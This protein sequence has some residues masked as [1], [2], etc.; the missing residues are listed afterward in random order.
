MARIVT[1]VGARPQLVKAAVV[2]IALR[3][4]AGIEEILVHTGQHYDDAMSAV[5]FRELG[6]PDPSYNLG[7]GSGPHGRQTGSMLSALEEVLEKEKP[8]AVMVYG[9]TNSTLAGALAAAKLSLRVIHVEAGLRS[10]NRQM[11]EEIN[12]V[13][14]DH[15][16][17]LLFAPTLTARENLLHEGLGTRRIELPGDVMYDA[18]LTFS[19]RMPEARTAPLL[20]EAAPYVLATVHR[21]ENTDHATRLKAILSALCDVSRRLP[22]IL[23]LHPRTRAVIGATFDDDLARFPNLILCP[24]VGYLEMLQLERN[25]SLVVT[26]SGGV[27]KEAFFFRV[28]C[29]TVREETEWVE[30]VESGW[31]RLAPPHDIDTIL[32]AISAALDAPQGRADDAVEGLFGG[33][34]AGSRIARFI[35]EFVG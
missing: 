34:L 11:P 28:P 6:I 27:Q 12:R 15:L 2:S 35:R 1:V 29:V 23:P 8:D 18:T 13:T 14:T 25:A 21:A 20:P 32:Q 19:G 30:L 17:D 33:G 4:T 3:D 24:P 7:I 26:D 16:S 10:F 5:F 22:V 9:D 31:N